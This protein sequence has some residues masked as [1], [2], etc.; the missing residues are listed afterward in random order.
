MPALLAA[1]GLASP[2]ANAAASS[3]PP[4][5]RLPLGPRA[6]AP[7]TVDGA[8]APIP[9]DVP[10]LLSRTPSVAMALAPMSEPGAAAATP[11]AGGGATSESTGFLPSWLGDDLLLRAILPISIIAVLAVALRSLVAK[12]LGRGGRPSGVMEVLARYPVGRGQ[13]VMLLRVGRRVLVVHQADRGMRTLSETTDPDEAAEL[14]ARSRETSK[15]SFA[16][17]LARRRGGDDPFEGAEMVDLTAARPAAAVMRPH[18]A[19]SPSR[20]RTL[21]FPEPRG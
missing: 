15:D 10:A 1:L 19:T 11:P 17:L 21:A 2:G 6:N 18:A 7:A 14:I 20:E 4:Q 3:V 5:E 8:S 12:G 9:R 16:K 13:H